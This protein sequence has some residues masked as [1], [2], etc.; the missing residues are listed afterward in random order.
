[1]NKINYN[2]DILACLASLSNDEVFTQ[3]KVVSEMLDLLPQQLWT[4]KN[5]KFLDP[6][7]KTG[8]FLREIAKRLMKGL[9]KQIPDKQKRINHILTNQ[10]YGIAIT[11]LTALISRRSLYCSKTANGKYSVCT[12]FTNKEGNIKFNNI[13][14]TWENGRCEYCG[15]SKEIYD[16]GDELESH[17]YEFIHIDK[18]EEMFKMKFDVIIGNPPYQLSDGGGRESSAVPLYHK[19]VEQAKKLNP[20]YLI[21]IIPARWY[22]G[23]KGLDEFRKSMLNDDRLAQI[24]DFP[25]TSDCF[26]GL[27]IRGGVCYFLWGKYHKGDC[28][29]VNHR[30]GVIVSSVKR[31]LL[32]EKSDV[33]VRYNQAI[34]ILRKVRDTKDKTLETDV[35]ARNP[36]GIASN[37]EDFK[38]GKSTSEN[39]KLYRFGEP[40][41]IRR[42][43][44]LK[45][46]NLINK[47]KVI[48]SKA[49]PGGDEYPHQVLTYPI[50][51]EPG[52]VCTETYLI[53]KEAKS[54]Q[55][56]KNIISYITTKFF[57]FM[58]SLIK[59][60]QNIS[61][62]VYAFVPIQD[63]EKSWTDEE[64]YKKYNLTKEEIDFIEGMIKPL[65]SKSIEGRVIGEENDSEDN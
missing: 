47:W 24:H 38:K 48:V 6:V 1:M 22:A 27:N 42:D 43:Q 30:R 5:A 45:S 11:E 60:T 54:E 55:E 18:P 65:N 8:I 61:R 39:I 20:S 52:A 31:P 40:G 26:P 3:P 16:R 44:V 28:L 15:A 19:F 10:L 41:Y 35:S 57:R 9:E 50:I 59:N 2:P 4:D 13:K 34:S 62:A 36:F 58:V 63:F 12:T 37:F 56:A 7:S 25:E 33:F 21:M 49:S 14:H 29:V 46:S 23:G 51:A 32:E 53:I 64:L 17:A